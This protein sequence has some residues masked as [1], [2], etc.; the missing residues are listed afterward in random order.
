VNHVP[1][2]ERAAR[3]GVE[4]A[5]T[6][7]QISSQVAFYFWLAFALLAKGDV[8]GAD[9]AMGKSDEMAHLIGQA[10]AHAGA[11][12]I[13]GVLKGD[14]ES[15]LE[16]GRKLSK[17]QEGTLDAGWQ[18]V[19]AML[20]IA[21][22]EKAA[23]SEMLRGIYDRTVRAGAYGC[24]VRARIYQAM[25]A[26]NPDEALAFLADALARGEPE[27][28]IRIFADEPKLLEPLLRQ[29]LGR[30]IMPEYTSTLLNVIDIENLRRKAI[31]IKGTAGTVTPQLLSQ[32]ELEVLGLIADG[33]SNQQIAEKLSVSLNTAKTHVH[34][35]FD[36]LEAKD[37][38]QAVARARDLKLI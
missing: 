16:W 34:H 11:R 31:G 1:E 12:V 28:Y 13:F 38:L 26:D 18:H 29:A 10:P 22:G 3:L 2:A 36:K 21:K 6:S 35:L 32:R 23:A 14:L 17:Y 27:H 19:P 37:R 4:L 30:G 20:L 15:A 8:P 24:L 7:G 9:A 33:L 25:A 5:E